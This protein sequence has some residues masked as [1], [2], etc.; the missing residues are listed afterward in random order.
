V[1]TVLAASGH[2]VYVLS[3]VGVRFALPVRPCCGTRKNSF[4][5]CRTRS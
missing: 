3:V 5:C 4:T 1:L 2:I